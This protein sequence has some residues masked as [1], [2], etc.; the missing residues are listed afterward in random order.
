MRPE[1]RGVLGV[2]GSGEFK[3]GSIKFGVTLLL[4]PRL[5]FL[6]PL[7]ADRVRR[8]RSAPNGLLVDFGLVS[9]I[10]SYVEFVEVDVDDSELSST[11]RGGG[12]DTRRVFCVLGVV[13]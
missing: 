1:R 13:G 11:R 9:D 8:R 12:R 10:L 6:P 4:P 3:D 2:E 5:V 7:G